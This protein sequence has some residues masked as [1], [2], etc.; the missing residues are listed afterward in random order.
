MQ[1]QFCDKWMT[2]EDMTAA[3]LDLK[4]RKAGWN[5]VWLVDPHSCVAFGRTAASAKNNAMQLA[6]KQVEQ[7]FNTAELCFV[8]VTKYLGFSVARVTLSVR[9]IQKYA[10]LG[11]V[12]EMI[13]RKLPAR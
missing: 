4:V 2:V 11:L 1:E 6:L 9:Q 8:K 3:A 10:S 5:F 13:L 12:D 7:R